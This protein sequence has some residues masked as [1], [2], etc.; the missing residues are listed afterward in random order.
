MSSG[1]AQE[2][3]LST[4]YVWAA[5]YAD[6]IRRT[7]YAQLKDLIKE[8]KVLREQVPRDIAQLNSALYKLIVEDLKMGKTDLVRIRINYVI[9]DNSIEWKPETLT[10][11]AFRRIPQEEVN[12]HV[13]RLRSSWKEALAVGVAYRFEELGRTEDE[14]VVYMIK[15]GESEA[16]AIMVTVLDNEIYV[17]RGALIY[18]NPIVFEK[19]RVKLDE[20]KPE[21]VFSEII[22][23]AESI[24]SASPSSIVRFVSENEALNVINT[25]RGRVKAAPISSPFMV[26]EGEEQSES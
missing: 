16:G 9:K 10:V 12:Q 21:E 2:R 15:L 13:D 7:V 17:K 1:E 6:K 18:P 24:R 20:K 3:R 19:V 14:D 25:L 8:N 5:T 22:R 23:S 11:E 4:G 26:E